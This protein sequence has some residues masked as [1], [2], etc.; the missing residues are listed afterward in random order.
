M[1][2]P[3][4]TTIAGGLPFD[5]VS[6]L[7][8]EA[9][10]VVVGENI[11]SIT[12]PSA[13]EPAPAPAGSRDRDV[14]IDARGLTVLPGLVDCHTHLTATGSPDIVAQVTGD[15]KVTATVHAVRA[16][17]A[18]LRA[19]ITT[20][21]DCGARGGVAIDVSR[22]VERGLLPGPGILA[23]GRALTMTGGHGHFVGR[24]ADGPEQV[25]RATRAEIKDGAQFISSAAHGS[26]ASA[27]RQRRAGS[28]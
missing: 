25:R 10:I 14:V 23:A 12:R 7:L 26:T 18:Y 9:T 5:G 17:A 20:V 3:S 11:V 16:A 15:S 27:T 19:G 8:A 21:R 2:S 22:S 13:A 4:R 24:E 1:S 28:S 6:P